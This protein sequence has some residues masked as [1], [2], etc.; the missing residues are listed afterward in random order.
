MV[1]YG[2]IHCAGDNTTNFCILTKEHD[3]LLVDATRDQLIIAQELIG[4][5]Y[6]ISVSGKQSLANGKPFDLK[7]IDFIDYEK[8]VNKSNLDLMT[9]TSTNNWE[10]VKDVDKWLTDLRDE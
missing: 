9:I 6:G 3:K 8:S 2:K 7:L 4:K 1:L 10:D 5:V